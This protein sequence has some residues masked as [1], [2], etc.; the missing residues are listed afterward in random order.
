[1]ITQT[2]TAIDLQYFSKRLNAL[3]QDKTKKTKISKDD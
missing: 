1:M 2:Y 3:Q